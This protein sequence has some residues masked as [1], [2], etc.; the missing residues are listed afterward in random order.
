MNNTA[1]AEHA[2]SCIQYA[3]ELAMQNGADSEAVAA[4]WVA[5]WEVDGGLEN[6]GACT[7]YR[8]D[9]CDVAR[10]TVAHHIARI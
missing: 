3:L 9:G 6:Y 7:C 8:Y 2:T 10:E 1:T 4:E 5:A